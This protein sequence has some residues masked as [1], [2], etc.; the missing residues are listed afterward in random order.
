MRKMLL[1]ILLLASATASAVSCKDIVAER[2][3]LNGRLVQHSQQIRLI[4]PND[5]FVVN[6]T[7]Y[8]NTSNMT[9]EE[10]H[11]TLNFGRTIEQ[12]IV[13]AHSCESLMVGELK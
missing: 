13:T 8:Q 10:V 11:V 5:I 12:H 4:K 3:Y 1:P 6:N 9:F 2:I 7:S